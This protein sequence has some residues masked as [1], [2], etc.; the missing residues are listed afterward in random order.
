[1]G[2]ILPDAY[3]SSLP[4]VPRSSPP[5]TG[6]RSQFV[7]Y[8]GVISQKP[9]ITDSRGSY[10]SI[11]DFYVTHLSNA[12]HERNVVGNSDENFEVRVF[13]KKTIYYRY[14]ESFQITGFVQTR[15]W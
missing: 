10:W 7:M 12:V 8:L 6:Y 13:Q 5:H 9:F 15:H 14:M 3:R 11:A 1:M 4:R 2:V